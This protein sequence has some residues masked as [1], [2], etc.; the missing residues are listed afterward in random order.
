MRALDRNTHCGLWA[1]L[2]TPWTADGALAIDTLAENCTRL[3]AAGVDGIYTTDSDG[4]FYAIELDVFQKFA[5]AFGRAMEKTGGVVDAAM[6]VTWSSTRGIIDRAKSACD[7]GIPNVH[8]AFPFFMPL[9]KSDIDHFFEDLAGAVPQARW[10]HYAHPRSGP[11]L[12][13]TEYAC[14]AARFPERFI[15]TKL[16][17]TDQTQLAEVL[18]HA[19]EL[20][21]FVVDPIMLTG[22]MLGAR[23]CCSYWVNTLPRWQRRYMIA[24]IERRWDEAR[25]FHLKLIEW[26]LTHIS[27]LRAAG[28]LHGI[29]GKSRAA[30]S[31]FLFD[32]GYTQPPYYP[33]D[34]QIRAQLKQAFERYWADEILAERELVAPAEPARSVRETPL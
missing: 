2:P 10:I 31:D 21:H 11:A 3:G 19:P 6:G 5:R 33:V 7:A 22:M 18:L 17:Y 29:I 20:S 28:H 8:V 4:E 14:L 15:G 24:C 27:T 9:A 1:A 34:A 30:L 23:G 32:T 26:E 12:T 25:A 16:G 13:G